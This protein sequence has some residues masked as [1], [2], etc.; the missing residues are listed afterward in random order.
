MS[1]SNEMEGAYWER[2]DSFFHYSNETFV[3]DIDL[4]FPVWCHNLFAIWASAR[5]RALFLVMW[6]R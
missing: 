4:Q 6:Q 1:S 2:F 5:V 3:S